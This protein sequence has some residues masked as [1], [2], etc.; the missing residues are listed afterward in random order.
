M[1]GSMGIKGGIVL[2]HVGYGTCL[3]CPIIN[4]VTSCC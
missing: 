3:G 4:V 1:L 2:Y